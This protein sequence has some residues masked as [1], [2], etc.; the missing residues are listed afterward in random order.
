MSAKNGAGVVPHSQNRQQ[1]S[2]TVGIPD[3]LEALPVRSS[4][5]RSSA[6]QARSKSSASSSESKSMSVFISE[7]PSTSQSTSTYP[8]EQSGFAVAR[9]QL[10]YDSCSSYSSIRAFMD[11]KYRFRNRLAKW[12]GACSSQKLHHL[13][14]EITV[15]LAEQTLCIGCPPLAG[16]IK[17]LQHE[18]ARNMN[19][20]TCNVL[21]SRLAASRF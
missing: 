7:Q 20:S 16:W 13:R 11:S 9:K 12:T 6:E 17:S 19:A 10:G 18:I 8:K 3:H 14:R 4:V 1:Q 2:A 21:R 5:G 15:S